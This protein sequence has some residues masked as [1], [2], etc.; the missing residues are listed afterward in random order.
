M[1]Y[2]DTVDAITVYTKSIFN[3]SQ[4]D[5]L[6]STRVHLTKCAKFN[7]E[8]LLQPQKNVKS[9]IDL[10]LHDILVKIA[11]PVISVD[12]LCSRQRVTRG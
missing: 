11:C 10:V 1:V 5:C 3:V 8:S 7:Y 4:E 2:R 9:E 12:L 6:Q